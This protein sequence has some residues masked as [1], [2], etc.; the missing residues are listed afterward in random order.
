MALAGIRGKTALREP[1]LLQWKKGEMTAVSN[2]VLGGVGVGGDRGGTA[3]GT[4]RRKS[5]ESS[6]MD[7]KG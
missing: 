5:T 3:S 2:Q 7:R 1:S 6:P 4:G